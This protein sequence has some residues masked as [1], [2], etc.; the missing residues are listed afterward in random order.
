MPRRLLPSLPRGG[1]CCRHLGHTPLPESPRARRQHHRAGTRAAIPVR[2]ACL[3]ADV[4]AVRAGSDTVGWSVSVATPPRH[5]VPVTWPR[6]TACRSRVCPSHVTR[7][8]GAC[9]SSHVAHVT[10]LAC[11]HHPPLT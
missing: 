3:C 6:A 10:R 11:S 2:R 8:C 4:R 1:G 5:G 7:L 9:D